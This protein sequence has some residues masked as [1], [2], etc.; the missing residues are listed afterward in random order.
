MPHINEQYDFV[1]TI[2]I[3]FEGSVLLVNHPRYEMWTPIGGHVELDE[4]PETAL[5]R[6]VKEETGLEVTILSTKPK[7]TSPGSKSLLTPNYLDVHEA[8]PP[9]KHIALTYFARARNNKTTL[10]K[11]H[12]ALKWF[13][14]E[15][16]NNEEFD[17]RPI[18]V[19]Y[20]QEALKAAA[21]RS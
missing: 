11:E 12:K 13:K 20:A 15:E 8:N 17:L 4:D 10:S 3:V 19:F 6:E 21:G 1:V 18:I 16:L 2:Y 14:P 7:I 5:F 9:H